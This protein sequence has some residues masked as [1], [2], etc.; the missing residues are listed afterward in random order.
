M[1][2]QVN[3]AAGKMLAKKIS[4]SLCSV[5]KDCLGIVHHRDT[6]IQRSSGALT[7]GGVAEQK[8]CDGVGNGKARSAFEPEE[9]AAGIEFEKDVLNHA[10]T[11]AAPVR[12]FS[13]PICF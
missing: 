7:A 8:V 3:T 9:F 11:I 5:V 1:V 6:E 10:Q 2:L 13:S 12:Q 4:V